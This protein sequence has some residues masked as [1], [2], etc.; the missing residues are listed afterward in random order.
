MPYLRQDNCTVTKGTVSLSNESSEV[1]FV[2]KILLGFV[3]LTLALTGCG[4]ETSGAVMSNT[5]RTTSHSSPS[6][7]TVVVNSRSLTTSTTTMQLAGIPGLQVVSSHLDVSDGQDAS[8]TIQTTPGTKSSIEVDYSSGPSHDT[9][10]RTQTADSNGNVTWVWNVPSNT[11]PGTWNV[12]ITAGG[13]SI[14]LQLH[15]SK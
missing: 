2:R 13:K 10:L 14:V 6:T 8:L 12:T 11:T 3:L 7:T 4:Q 9:G 15:V 1:K 5:E